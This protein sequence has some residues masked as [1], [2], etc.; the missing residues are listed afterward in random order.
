[1]LLLNSL[2]A[3]KYENEKELKLILLSLD[4]MQKSANYAPWS[5]SVWF[6]YGPQS[7][8]FLRTGF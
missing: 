3:W 2:S 5:K 6:L 4:L 7:K 8:F 1:M